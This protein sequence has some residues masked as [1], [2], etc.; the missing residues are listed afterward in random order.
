MP[1]AT[2]LLKNG[3]YYIRFRVLGIRYKK[4]LR[5]SD[6]RAALAAQALIEQ[7]LQLIR[8]GQLTV[9]PDVDAGNFVVSGGNLQRPTTAKQLKATLEDLLLG[10]LESSHH[11]EKAATTRGTDSIH[12]K[13]LL[14]SCLKG[15]RLTDLTEADL[16]AYIDTRKAAG[17]VGRTIKA[18][19]ASFRSAWNNFGVV[20]RLISKDFRQHFPRRVALPKFTE[21]PRFQPLRDVPKGADRRSVYLLPDDV[22]ELLHVVEV[23]GYQ[24]KLRKLYPWVPAAVAFCLFTSFRRSTMRRARVEDIDFQRS[25][26]VGR[27]TKEDSS[28]DETERVVPLL[29]GLENRLNEW[30]HGRGEE[31]EPTHPGGSILFTAEPDQQLSPTQAHLGLKCFLE[32]TRFEGLGWHCFRHSF[33][34]CAAAAGVPLVIVNEF[35]G[36]GSDDV[37][38]IYRHLSP[39]HLAK[40]VEGIY[41]RKRDKNRPIFKAPPRSSENHGG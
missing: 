32:G 17:V 19:L 41:E 18:E 15:K 35:T 26:V 22:A 39:N 28:Y 30:L 11:G 34:S 12:C 7:T 3:N 33:A 9:P 8:L 36:H 5:T 6:D 14:R 37:A 29:P 10:F 23:K 2:L 24:A 1:A 31:G 25:T 38:R 40:E 20:S 16:Q 27:I 4:S 13:H 21:K